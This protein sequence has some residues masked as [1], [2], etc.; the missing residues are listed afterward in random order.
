MKILLATD[1]SK[2]P[3]RFSE[4]PERKKIAVIFRSSNRSSVAESFLKKKFEK[5]FSI[6]GAMSAL[7]KGKNSQL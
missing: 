5:V 3:E 7:K 6:I 4:N 1:D 2:F